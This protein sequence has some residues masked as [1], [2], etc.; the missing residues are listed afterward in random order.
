M[1]REPPVLEMLLTRLAFRFFG[2]AVYRAYAQRLPLQGHERVLDFGSGLGTVAAYVAPRLPRGQLV[3]ADISARWLAAC[4]KTL[5]AYPGVAFCLGDVY[6]LPLAPESFD[7]I[8]CH[9]VLHDIPQKEL[10][11]V[12]PSLA[13]LL[14]AGGGLAF[15]EPLGQ[16]E[17]LRLIQGLLEQH[18]LTQQEGRVTDVPV[19]GNALESIYRKGRDFG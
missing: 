10:E 19:I 5:R 6:D 14:K 13:G 15:R 17:A 12:I 18:G 11:K 4:R 16:G 2:K 3:C 1:G 7:L 8:Y 9:F